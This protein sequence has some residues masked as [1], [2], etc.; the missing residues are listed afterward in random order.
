MSKILIFIALLSIIPTGLS[1]ANDL[2]KESIDR[3]LNEPATQLLIDNL[4]LKN[5]TT[6]HDSD[7]PDDGCIS[8]P[9]GLKVC[10]GCS[11]G[12][13]S[14]GLSICFGDNCAMCTFSLNHGLNCSAG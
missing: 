3:F 10:A 4:V 12:K 1:H 5:T 9:E 11:A 14:C 2:N 6:G 13:G 7:S 8:N